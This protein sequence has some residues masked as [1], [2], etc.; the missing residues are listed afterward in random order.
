MV[1]RT[2]KVAMLFAG[3]FGIHTFTKATTETKF[4]EQGRRAE[5]ERRATEA[6]LPAPELS[7]ALHL[8]RESR[9]RCKITAM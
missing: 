1:S 3:A 9:L 5:A 6:K 8:G 7:P 2:F 4:I